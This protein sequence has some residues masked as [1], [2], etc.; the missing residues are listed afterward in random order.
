MRVISSDILGLVGPSRGQQGHPPA[1]SNFKAKVLW[2]GAPGHPTYRRP[3]HRPVWR[4]KGWHGC[5][6][7]TA[8]LP[9]NDLF[10]PSPEPKNTSPSMTRFAQGPPFLCTAFG[11]SSDWE[12][13]GPTLLQLQRPGRPKDRLAVMPEARKPWMRHSSACCTCQARPGCS[14]VQLQSQGG[15]QTSSA[16]QAQGPPQRPCFEMSLGQVARSLQLGPEWWV[17]ARTS[18]W[19]AH[20]LQEGWDF[21]INLCVHILFALRPGVITWH[22]EV[23]GKIPASTVLFLKWLFGGDYYQNKTESNNIGQNPSAQ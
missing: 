19:L 5:F 10:W 6:P 22:S 1:S 18:S 17:I 16:A 15:L 21:V 11:S 13:S 14:F 3:S 12:Q 2:Y 9:T 8:Q 23:M 7:P 20:K 4:Y